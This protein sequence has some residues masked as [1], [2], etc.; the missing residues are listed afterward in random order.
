MRLSEVYVGSAGKL[1][2]GNCFAD[3]PKYPHKTAREKG[4]VPGGFVR[5]LMAQVPEGIAEDPYE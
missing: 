5:G 1:R 3:T 2:G 4:T